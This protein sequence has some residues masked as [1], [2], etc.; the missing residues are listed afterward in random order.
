MEGGAWASDLLLAHSKDLDSRD[1]GLA[2]EIVFGVLRYRAQLD[3]LIG[4]F[5]GAPSKLDPEGRIALRMGMYQ[6]RYLERIPAHAA[7]GRAVELVEARAEQS[8]AGCVNA[9]LRKV[10]VEPVAWP[11]REVELS[12]PEWLLARWERQF[13]RGGGAGDRLCPR[14]KSR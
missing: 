11:N 7:V 9:V 3:F 4:H 5:S 14:S 10:N 12:C 6:I 13:G 1:A 8:A 2:A